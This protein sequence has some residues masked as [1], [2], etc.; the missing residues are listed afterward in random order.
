MGNHGCAEILILLLMAGATVAQNGS[1]GRP[2]DCAD[3]KIVGRSS[4]NGVYLIYPDGDDAIPITVYCDMETENGGWTVIQRRMDGSVDFYR[5]WADYKSGFGNVSSEHWLGN[6]KIHFLSRQKT[7]ELRIDLED[8]DGQKSFATY[9][10]F[11]VANE[12]TNYEL[13]RVDN[14]A[15]NAGDCLSY[16][17]GRPFSTRDRD[18]D[19]S[20]HEW[21]NCA[22]RYKG[23][24]WYHACH[25][26]NLNGQYGEK[27][28][29]EKTSH[30]VVWYDW[31]T[32]G[33]LP[34]T[35][36]KTEMKIR[37]TNYLRGL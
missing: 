36:R 11:S 31:A 32:G 21:E 28:S 17:A 18:N 3:I 9:S 23:G 34:Y 24:W 14:F 6:D 37:P 22:D 4:P 10:N 19:I 15:G 33:G 35:L 8:F 30:G 2:R 1:P 13:S 12:T 26:A 20:P 16:H 5:Y 25:Y 7:Y 27:R 29:A